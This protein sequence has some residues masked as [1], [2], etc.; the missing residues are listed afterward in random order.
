MKTQ[1][2]G[3]HASPRKPLVLVPQYF[4][5]IVFD[6]RTS[7][8]LPFDAEA[9][10]LLRRLETVPFPAVVTEI[11]DPGHRE[12]VIRFFEQFYDLGFF[13][14]DMRFDGTV[15]DVTPPADHLVGPLALHLEIVAACNLKCRHCFAGELPR[16]EDPL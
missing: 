15:L 11:A 16:R 2:S 7:R 13:T 12:P 1:V 10:A 5:S 9:T 8:Y 4:G 6:R 3:P 14:L